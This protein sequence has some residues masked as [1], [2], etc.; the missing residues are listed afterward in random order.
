M[1]GNEPW[2]MWPFRL[3]RKGQGKPICRLRPRLRLKSE[4]L[5]NRI[6]PAALS[7][8]V[9]NDLLADGVHAAAEPPVA[10]VS[11]VLQQGGLKVQQTVTNGGGAYSFA[12]VAPGAY[13]VAL[14]VPPNATQTFPQ[15]GASQPVQVGAVDI[16]GLAFGVQIAAAVPSNT[17]VTAGDN[18]VQQMPSVAVDPID[19]THVVMAYMDYSFL[20]NGYAKVGFAVSHDSGANWTRSSLPLPTTSIRQRASRWCVLMRPVGCSWH[21]APP[22]SWA[23]TRP[24]Q[25]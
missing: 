5:E 14:V 15:A 24:A 6:V 3:F 22:S 9:W 7:G 19:A 23:R 12:G 4:E 13:S 11:V 21:L 17:D 25:W 2:Y 8:V 16:Q 20:G 1:K 18:A 10:N